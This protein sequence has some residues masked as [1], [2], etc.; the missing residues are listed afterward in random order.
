MIK[1]LLYLFLFLL[2]FNTLEHICHKITKGFTLARIQFDAPAATP[3]T[4]SPSTYATLNQ[5]F[6]YF[7]CGN[8]CFVFISADGQ[9]ILKFFKY[10][11]H[12]PPA[13]ITKI[14]LL[15]R[16]KPLR[17]H[18]LQKTVWKRERDFRGYQIAY[19]KFREESGLLCLHLQPTTGYPT[20]TLYD[21]LG[22]RHTLNLNA[23]PFVLQKKATSVYAQFLTWLKSGEIKK[24]RSAIPQLVSLCEKR[25]SLQLVDDDVNFY[26]NTGFVGEAPILIDPGHFTLSPSPLPQEELTTALVQLEEWFQQH[27]PPLVHDVQAYLR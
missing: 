11:S 7:G 5:P 26:A 19:D 14:P 15:N 4:I 13:W 6:H 10:A 17:P 8:Q 3:D 9:N 24:I 23:T 22:I 16:F 25:I 18:R 1:K 12:T 20:I 21:K 2:V 27:Y